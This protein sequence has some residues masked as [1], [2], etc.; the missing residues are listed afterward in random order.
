M[1]DLDIVGLGMATLDVLVRLKDMPT[2]ER[3]SRMSAFSFDGGG[4]VATAMVAA[5][6][7]GAKVGFIGTA[8]NDES[9]DIKIR[10]LTRYGVDVSHLMRRPTPEMQVVLVCV[11][12]ET[13]ERVFSGLQRFWDWS[14]RPEE[15]DRYY[16]TSARFLHLDGSHPEAAQQA[17]IWMHKAGKLVMYDGAKVGTRARPPMGD[18]IQHVD[19]LIC[20]SGF[21]QALTGADGIWEAGRAALKIGPRIVVQTEGE[22]GAYTVTANDEF[23]TP[24]FKVNVVDTTGAGDVFHGAYL[25][26]LLRGWDL[27]RTA[28]FAT[29]VAAIK[30]GALGGRA[31]IPSY[32]QAIAFLRE[33]GIE[34]ESP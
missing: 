16:I 4:P 28:L 7:L 19:I 33:R 27:R 6:R 23:H 21:A 5:A 22:D 2:W 1:D 30:C 26:G 12:E 29:A 10:S 11:H 31:G 17:A 15:L 25:V 14:L 20:G 18:L 8:G 34:I 9:A 24:A 3:G 32:D 13:G